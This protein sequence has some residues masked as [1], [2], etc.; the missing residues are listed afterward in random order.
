MADRST[1]FDTRLIIFR[2][3]QIIL[4][5]LIG[6]CT[7]M[8]ALHIMNSSLNGQHW[9]VIGLPLCLI[10]CAFIFYPATEKWEYKAWQNK[11][12]MV[13]QDLDL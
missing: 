4:G 5:I 7:L 6:I 1:K 2:T 8:F 11:P 12:K 3:R 9:F 10:A 13:E